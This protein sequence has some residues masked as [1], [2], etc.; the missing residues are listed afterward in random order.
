MFKWRTIIVKKL[1]KEKERRQF[2]V[3]THNANIPVLGDSEL[4]CVL[5]ADA[6]HGYI[7]KGHSGSIDDKSVRKPVETILEGGREAFEL[8]KEKYGF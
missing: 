4:I 6:E 5:S 7:D 1:R 2:I 3:A 8:R